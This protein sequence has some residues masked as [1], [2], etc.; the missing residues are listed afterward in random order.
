RNHP[1]AARYAL[2]RCRKALPESTEL[3]DAFENLF[4]KNSRLPMLARKDYHLVGTEP[5]RSPQWK[6]A[7]S[8]G[9]SGKLMESVKA[10][11][12][13]TKAAKP[14]PLA[15]YNIAL[16]K[17]WLGDNHGAVE[18]LEKYVEREANEPRAS[19]AWG[20]AE[21]L[22]LGDDMLETADW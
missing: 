15:W 21:V 12:E 20:L 7:L 3:A 2:D 4:G 10:F 16:L 18:A 11:E 13:L 5:A 22:Y 14:D 17:T 8:L 1:V 19:E 6:N 9:R